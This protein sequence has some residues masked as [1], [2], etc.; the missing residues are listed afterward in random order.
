MSRPE[1]SYRVAP[2][3][4]LTAA[5]H[6]ALRWLAQAPETLER[7]PDIK[8]VTLRALVRKGL[9]KHRINP[10]RTFV[11]FLDTA[12]DYQL[13]RKGEELSKRLGRWEP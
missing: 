7:S 10:D 12:F 2:R 5:Q 1:P 6:W 11:S 8:V 3:H 4:G 9:I 13:T